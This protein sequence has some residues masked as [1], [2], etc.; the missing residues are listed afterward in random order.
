MYMCMDWLTLHGLE[1]PKVSSIISAL[2]TWHLHAFL[3]PPPLYLPSEL[4]M[5]LMSCRVT[6]P[7]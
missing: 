1:V 4:Q 6:A 2:S 5:I 3:S 7:S